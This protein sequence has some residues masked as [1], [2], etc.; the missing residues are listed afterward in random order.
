MSVTAL[1]HPDESRYPAEIIIPISSNDLP[2]S[3]TTFSKRSV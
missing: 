3:H 2:D 1:L